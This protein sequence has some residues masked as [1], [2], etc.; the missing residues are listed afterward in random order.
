MGYSVL[1]VGHYLSLGGPTQ[2]PIAESPRSQKECIN[3]NYF[4]NIK[5]CLD[6]G[7]DPSPLST[8]DPQHPSY[9]H[10]SS[11]MHDQ[12]SSRQYLILYR[13][14]QD[15]RIGH[16]IHSW[17]NF[18]CQT[19]IQSLWQYPERHRQRQH[20]SPANLWSF[21]PDSSPSS[22]SFYIPRPSPLL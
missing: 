15:T 10:P 7:Q 3:S 22:I 17:F 1:A 4:Q 13:K 9:P 2:I 18:H 16:K 12:S 5:T 20:E 14:N 19:L 8:A 6:D 11:G 21:C